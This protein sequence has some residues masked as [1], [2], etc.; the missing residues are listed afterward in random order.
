MPVPKSPRINDMMTPNSGSIDCHVTSGT[1][2]TVHWWPSNM[3]G[4]TYASESRIRS[5][6]GAIS[7]AFRNRE[8]W[9]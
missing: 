6:D 1:V 3:T 9:T 8:L 7:P 2:K 4:F 5:K